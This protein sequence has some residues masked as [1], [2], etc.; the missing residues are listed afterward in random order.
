MTYP[1]YVEW[2]DFTHKF[3]AFCN[4]PFT[5]SILKEKATAH[6]GVC[7]SNITEQHC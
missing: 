3:H 6:V 1:G 4:L 7:S 2:M 5:A